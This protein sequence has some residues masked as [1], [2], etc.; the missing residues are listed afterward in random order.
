MN[1][2]IT[3]IREIRYSRSSF[4]I[5][6]VTYC[7]LAAGLA[8]MLTM[9][10]PARVLAMILL[11]MLIFFIAFAVYEYFRRDF[12]TPVITIGPQGI[13]DIR[14][15]VGFIPWEHM[16]GVIFAT[17]DPRTAKAATIFVNMESKSSLSEGLVAKIWKRSKR[18]R[19]VLIRRGQFDTQFREIAAAIDLYYRAYKTRAGNT[20][21]GSPQRMPA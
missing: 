21:N 19:P 14:I 3:S 5:I 16:D 7:F 13:Q 9:E 11:P 12:V 18:P 6:L 15:A 8:A 4:K 2:D 20:E 10:G 17:M 1:T